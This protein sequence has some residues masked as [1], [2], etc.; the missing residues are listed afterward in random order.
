[1]ESRAAK[2]PISLR[3]RLA[4]VA[5]LLFVAVVVAAGLSALTVRSFNR[6][7]EQQTEVRL[8][9]DEVAEL[10]LASTEQETGLQGYLLGEDPASLDQLRRSQVIARRA[11]ERLDSR[12]IGTPDFDEQLAGVVEAA[13]V[14]NDGIVAPMLGETAGLPDDAVASDVFDDLR[15]QLDELNST[16]SARV[17]EIERQSDRARRATLGVL[18]GAAL[19]AVVGALLVTVLFRRWVTGPLA[20]ISDAARTVATDEQSELPDFDTPELQ[21]VTDAIRALQ[22]SLVGARDRAVTAYDGLEQSALLALRVRAELANELGEMPPGWSADSRLVPAE[23]VVAGDCYDVGLLDA[24]RLYVVMID[25][26]GHGATAALDALQAKGQLRAGLRSRMSP[27]AAL[28]WFSRQQRGETDLLTAIVAI[29][30]LDTGEC[31]FANAGHPPAV[32]TDGTELRE[33]EPTGPLLGAFPAAWA[34][35]TVTIPPDW[36]LF[37]YTDGVIDAVGDGRDRFGEQR[38][39]E[40]L[41]DGPVGP[42]DMIR[43]VSDCV[44]EFRVG[45]RTDD[46]TT[47]ALRREC[48]ACDRRD[49]RPDVPDSLQG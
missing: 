28:A 31:E 10:Q 39:H 21:D 48:S 4:I 33:L 16:V 14:W 1:M 8:V 45:P 24:S 13:D 23:G 27:G 18:A 19:A 30:H 12:S 26:T 7:L 2:R 5:L 11:L 25:V 42:G 35:V 32:L 43:K 40:C 46:I 47:L 37:M 15:S 6:S 9:A 3:G 38:L 34:T 49:G 41:L 44:E 29:V 22:T 20:R 36:T 17:D